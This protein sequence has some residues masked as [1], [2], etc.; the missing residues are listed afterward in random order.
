MALFEIEKFMKQYAIEEQFG[1]TT[2]LK[3][4]TGLLTQTHEDSTTYGEIEPEENRRKHGQ[5]D[6]PY[7]TYAGYGYMFLNKYVRNVGFSSLCYGL[8]SNI[9]FL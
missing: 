3:L 5:S 9:S 8:T 1:K 6:L 2:K 4:R 7:Y